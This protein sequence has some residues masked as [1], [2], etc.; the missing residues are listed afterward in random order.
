MIIS[1]R[2]C[3]MC[4][5]VSSRRVLSFAAIYEI[6]REVNTTAFTTRKT[7]KVTG[8]SWPT[9]AYDSPTHSVRVLFRVCVVIQ[10]HTRSG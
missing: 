2:M 7:Y 8:N 5:V 3:P 6:I 1:D 4:V 9:R 10:A